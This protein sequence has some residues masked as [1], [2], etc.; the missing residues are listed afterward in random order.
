MV[1]DQR[2]FNDEVFGLQGKMEG[3]VI[4]TCEKAAWER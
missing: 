1:V 4:R 3:P 2:Q